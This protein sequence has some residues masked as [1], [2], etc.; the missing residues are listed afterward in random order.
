MLTGCFSPSSDTIDTFDDA[1][2]S[3][4]RVITRAATGDPIYPILVMAYDEAGALKGQQTITKPEQG[5]SLQLAEGSYHITALSGH[6][7]Y[8]EPDSYS[9]QS[10]LISIPAAGYASQP[11][12]IGGADVYLS[13]SSAS[14]NVV[15]TFR[16][17]SLQM[18]LAEVPSD[19]TA[20]SIGISQQH[21]AIDMTGA[22]N[23]TK[24]VN[25]PCYK[26]GDV[27][28]SG[29]VYVMPGAGTSTTLTL[30]LTNATGQT[31][32]SY[33]L[34]E[35]LSAAVPY[36]IRGT[37]VEATVPTITGVI[38]IEGWGSERTIDFDFGN[39]SSGG[40]SSS[41]TT[42]PYV[43]DT[44][45]PEAGSE[46]EGHVVA[47][48][49]NVTDTEADLLLLALHEETNI[50]APAAEGYETEMTDFVAAYSEAGLSDWRVPTEDEA[51]ALKKAYGGN[52]E[53]LNLVVEGLSGDAITI[54]TTSNNARYL[55]A[56][57]TK[58]FNFAENGSITSAG[59]SV[60][61]RLRLVKRVHVVVK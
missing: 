24:T 44:K 1:A 38:T 57:G 2:T 12:M 4:L 47:L 35:P 49:E 45:I 18:S 14:V 48:T 22:F 15:M 39:G 27:W 26:E 43:S 10:S 50:H 32:Y 30:S 6:T 59:T 42:T 21:G 11:L 61:Y 55:C 60:K 7:S 51:R 23:G 37:Y 34:A 3:K 28:S 31:S 13:N 46:W 58:T 56:D 52:F 53:E 9:L 29:Q 33:E 16:V 36:I 5:I 19:V 17:A 41:G 8:D 20:V 40:G 25:I 54:A